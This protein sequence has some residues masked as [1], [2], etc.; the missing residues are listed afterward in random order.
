MQKSCIERFDSMDCSAA[1]NFCDNQLST[2]MWATGMSA[3]LSSFD[4]VKTFLYLGRNVYD[5]TKVR[6]SFTQIQPLLTTLIF[7]TAMRR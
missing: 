4:T 2:A 5:I 3:R 1:V 6:S 7:T